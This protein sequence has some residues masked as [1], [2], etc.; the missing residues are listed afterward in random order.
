MSSVV[1]Y[2]HPTM[3]DWEYA[4]VV[5]GLVQAAQHR[6]DSTP[7]VVVAGVS[8]EPVRTFG[9]L[10]VVPDTTLDQLDPSDIELLLLPGGNDWGEPHREVFALAKTLLADG[11]AVAGIC[12][13]VPAMAREGLLDEV[14][15]TGNSPEEFADIDYRGD[16]RYLDASAVGSGDVITA[17]GTAPLEFSREVF[18]RLGVF[19]EEEIEQWYAAFTQQA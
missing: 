2:A 12:G 5:T 17:A 1:L 3:A 6:P 13:A 7:R 8:A 9:G 16:A 4:Y 11:R 14:P 18:R 10:Q 15:H 19:S